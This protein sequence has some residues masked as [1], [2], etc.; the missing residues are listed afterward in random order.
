MTAGSESHSRLGEPITTTIADWARVKEVDA[1]IWTDLPGNFKDFTVPNAVR[2]LQAL[3]GS[4]LDRA[5]EYIQKTPTQIET[6]V[7][8]KARTELT[9]KRSCG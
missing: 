8:K 1:V 3:T 6:A 4:K 2:Y 5:R 7:R 9:W